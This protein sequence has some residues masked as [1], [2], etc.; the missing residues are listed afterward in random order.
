MRTRPVARVAVALVAMSLI[1]AACSTS[2]NSGGGGTTSGNTTPHK[3]GS[4]IFGAEQWTGCLNPVTNCAGFSLAYVTVWTIVLPR[5]M[6][7]DLKNNFVASSL[8]TAIHS[9]E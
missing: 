9:I 6:Q 1:A 8:L 2:S 3:G 7:V 5:A 4:I